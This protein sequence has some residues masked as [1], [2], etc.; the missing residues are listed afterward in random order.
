MAAIRKRGN[1][2]TEWRLRAALMRNSIS[3]WTLHESQVLGCP[4]FWFEDLRLAVFVDG[5]FWHGCKRCCRPPKSNTSYWRPKIL[6]NIHRDRAQGRALRKA[7]IRVIRI[8]EHD[9]ATL[10]SR[11]SAISRLTE[12]LKA[13]AREPDSQF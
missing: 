6:R 8:W 1:R 11:Q 12:A 3:G 9:L 10:A 7:N 4:D 13:R 2:S 5:C